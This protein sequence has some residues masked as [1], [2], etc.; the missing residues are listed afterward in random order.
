MNK[1]HN[2]LA[3]SPWVRRHSEATPGQKNAWRQMAIGGWSNATIAKIWERSEDMVAREL[4]DLGAAPRGNRNPPGFIQD[5]LDREIPEVPEG[6][7]GLWEQFY[8]QF[9]TMYFSPKVG[10]DDGA[11]LTHSKKL[12]SEPRLRAW[13]FEMK[14]R[15]NFDGQLARWVPT[16]EKRNLTRSTPE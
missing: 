9:I 2:G 4:A 7:Q 5:F 3:Y 1:I 15:Y 13:L 8:R 10:G 14:D 6:L 12:L 16:L 11:W